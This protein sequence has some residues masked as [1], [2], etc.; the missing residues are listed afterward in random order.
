LVDEDGGSPRRHGHRVFEDEEEEEE[1]RRGRGLYSKSK[2]H[3]AR[4][5][6]YLHNKLDRD[7][8]SFADEEEYT[9]T[10]PNARNHGMFMS[11]RRYRI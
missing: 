4:Y 6:F 5:Y 1:E 8:A 10:L 9:L 3:L 11:M 7:D 2:F